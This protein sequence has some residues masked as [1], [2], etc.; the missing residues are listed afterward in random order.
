[1]SQ[2]HEPDEQGNIVDQTEADL[3]EGPATGDSGA[4]AALGTDAPPP[5]HPAS[6]VPLG[7]VGEAD[8]RGGS[9]SAGPESSSTGTGGGTG[10]DPGASNVPPTSPR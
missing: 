6:A 5:G 3:T 10:A 9:G 8:S 1:M 7:S 2:L 4:A